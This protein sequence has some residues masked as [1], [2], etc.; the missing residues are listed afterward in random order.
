QQI[1]EGASADIV[2][3]DLYNDINEIAKYESSSREIL[4]EYGLDVEE[5]DAYFHMVDKGHVG[6]GEIAILLQIDREKASNIMEK[7]NEKGLI[8]KIPG[9][10]LIYQALPPYRALL[11]QI[12]TFIPFI[13]SIKNSIPNSTNDIN[14]LNEKYLS[15]LSELETQIKKSL[16]TMDALFKSSKAKITFKFKNLW[17]IDGAEAIISEITDIMWKAKIRIYIVAPTIENVNLSIIRNLPQKITIRLA[18]FIDFDNQNHLNIANQLSEYNINFRLY[19]G[20]NLW[21]IN[22]DQEEIIL[23]TVSKD[24]DVAAVASDVKEQVQLLA[25]VLE[26]AWIQGIPYILQ[27]AS[28]GPQTLA[29][30]E[31]EKMGF[32]KIET[33]EPKEIPTKTLQNQIKPI[34]ETKYEIPEK[35]SPSQPEPKKIFQGLTEG[36]QKVEEETNEGTEKKKK[37]WKIKE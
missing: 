14:E 32:E 2:C 19:K 29:I 12:N 35:S 26:K 5:T 33:S 20:Q 1:R 34:M 22:R 24:R 11:N 8:K 25:P 21:G 15:C 17:F 36:F 28:E 18:T 10:K 30:K 9:K 16:T 13:Q 3:T 31:F 37:F 7:L 4:L 23:G 6:V 27:E